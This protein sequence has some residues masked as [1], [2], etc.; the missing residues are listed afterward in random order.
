M[1][2][3]ADLLSFRQPLLDNFYGEPLQIVPWVEGDVLAGAADPAAPPF[4]VVGILD[5]PTKVDRVE[6]AASVVGARSDLVSP[7]PRVDFAATQFPPNHLP[8]EG[9]RVVALERAGQPQYRVSSVE[10]DGLGRIICA[11]I[12]I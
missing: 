7:V 6:G 10:P 2:R 3:Y 9:W 4:A 8:Q 1:S 5:V 11:L 12:A